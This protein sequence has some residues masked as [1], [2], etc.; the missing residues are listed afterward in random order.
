MAQQSQSPNGIESD[1][2]DV[3]APIS[4]R[5]GQAALVIMR[6]LARLFVS[7]G[8]VY[9]E[10][11]Q[12][13]KQAFFEAGRSELERAG[14][15][16]NISRISLG[17]GLHRRDVKRL[18][19]ELSDDAVTPVS[20]KPPR[21]IGSE[22]YMRWSTDPVLAKSN[23][24]LP[25]RAKDGQMSFEALAREVNTDAHPRSL[26]EDLRR[27]GLVV[28]N[29]EDE[30]VT[31]KPGG[32]VP[33]LEQTEMLGLLGDNLAAHVETAVANVVEEGPKFL[34]QSVYEND[35]TP[36]AV[37]KIDGLS[38]AIWTKALARLVPALSG[39]EHRKTEKTASVDSSEEGFQVRI[40]MY[41]HTSLPRKNDE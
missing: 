37:R 18:A 21:S 41:V 9:G 35:L 10:A 17:T 38:R 31:L 14:I 7:H 2:P 33:L 27:L 30:T 24:S 13:L 5:I 32:F 12:L 22:V 20:R 25:L 15:K 26:L 6:P 40:G 29:E 39:A 11:E 3:R 36:E 4:A 34:E 16:S 19:D 28:V 1:A 8:V 23:N